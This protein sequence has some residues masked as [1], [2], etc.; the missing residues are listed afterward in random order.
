MILKPFELQNHLDKK[1]FLFYGENDGQKDEIIDKFFKKLIQIV[2]IITQRKKYFLTW[3]IFI[4][5][6]IHNLF[7]RIKN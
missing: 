4:I 3:I 5:K 1:I 6:L 2:F 7:L